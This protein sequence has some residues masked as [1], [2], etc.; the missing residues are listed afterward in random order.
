MEGVI[1]LVFVCETVPDRV[2][3]LVLEGDFVLLG[4]PVC[5]IVLEGV[6]DGVPVLLD[7]LEEVIVRVIVRVS[8][9]VPVWVIVLE[10]VLEGVCV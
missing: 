9:C 10:G 2:L 7:D 5:V 4:V 3:E 1:P 6:L 8:V